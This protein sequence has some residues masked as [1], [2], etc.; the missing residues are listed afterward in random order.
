MPPPRSTPGDVAHVDH[1]EDADGGRTLGPQLGRERL[2][3]A[4][5][6]DSVVDEHHTPTLHGRAADPSF[7]IFSNPG[8][9]SGTP[10]P[11][12]HLDPDRR[13][14]PLTTGPISTTNSRRRTLAATWR[15]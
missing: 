1:G 8:S 10:A 12:L 13:R 7:V 14:D 11:T 3:R 5:L 6:V 2:D 4:A 15:S 9:R